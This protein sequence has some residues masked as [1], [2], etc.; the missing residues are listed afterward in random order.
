MFIIG[1]GILLYGLHLMQGGLQ[2]AAKH[3][4]RTAL[5]RLAGTPLTA[6]LTG[7]IIT[8][9]IPSSTAVTVLAV[10]L[11]NSRV[12]TLAQAVGIV[13]GANVG[14]CVT[15]QLMALDLGRIAP[16]FLAAGII[17]RLAG[18]T[19]KLTSAGTALAGFG[20]IFLSLDMMAH[21]L[22]PLSESPRFHQMLAALEGNYPAAAAAGAL[23]TGLIHSSSAGTGVV[24]TLTREGLIGLPEAVALVLGNNVGTC[25]TGLLAGMAGSRA[26][27]RV[28]VAH[29]LINVAGAV[30]ILPL[31]PALAAMLPLL[32]PGAGYQIAAAHTIFNVVSTLV[33]LPFIHPFVRMLYVLLPRK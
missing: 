5:L 2:Q 23:V 9:L 12:M 7:V 26:G 25:F 3:R 21:A 20:A 11:V 8:C 32:G 33:V 15:V 22:G 13:L 29:L 10:G 18:R 30:V 1:I 28:A 31:V 6:A 4:M 19:P 17:L 14:T 27:K 16:L 24:I